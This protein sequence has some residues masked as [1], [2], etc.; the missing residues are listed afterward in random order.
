MTTYAIALIRISDRNEYTTYEQ[1]FMEIFKQ[2]AP[3]Q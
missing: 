1:G 2:I 3:T